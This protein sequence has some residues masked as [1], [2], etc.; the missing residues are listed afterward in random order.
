MVKYV[1]LGGRPRPVSFGFG[2][3]YQ[4]ETNTGTAIGTVFE[5]LAGGSLEVTVVLNLILAGLECGA[6]RERLEIAYSQAEVADWLDTNPE[7][8]TEILEAFT[9]SFVKEPA[10]VK[11]A[12][13]K[14]AGPAKLAGL[15]P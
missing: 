14:P 7:A 11:G 6:R 12:K 8:V 13:K 3:L 1:N 10:E 5:K 2:A 4:F 9:A 15:R